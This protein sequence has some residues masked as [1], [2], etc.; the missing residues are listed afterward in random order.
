MVETKKQRS[1]ILFE[2]QLEVIQKFANDNYDGDF[3]QGLR[4]I[5]RLWMEKL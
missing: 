1:V 2:T 3:S 5:V 4:K